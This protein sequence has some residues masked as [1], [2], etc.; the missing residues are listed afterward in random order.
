MDM[1]IV[2][3][4][5]SLFQGLELITKPGIRQFV[6]IP[7]LINILIFSI[8]LV[9]ANHYLHHFNQ[10]LA[11]YIPHWLLWLSWVIWLFFFLSFFVMFIYSFTTL[12]NIISAPFN[13]LLAE[14]VQEYLTGTIPASC[15]WLQSLKNVPNDFYRQISILGYYLPRALALLILFFVP[16]IHIF[17]G[18][19]WLIFNAW[20]LSLQYLDYPAV[21]HHIPLRQLHSLI[22]SK[23]S[24]C[25]GLGLATLFLSMIP[26]LNFIVMPV[27]IAGAT[28]LWIK[29][30]Q[31]NPRLTDQ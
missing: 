8:F 2:I 17:A 25:L 22:K 11:N 6:I 16:V 24:A 26:I 4:I 31:E 9:S 13:S 21:N 3:G 7:M 10:W 1:S 12:T 29:E 28:H 23:R 19:F 14:K 20:F 18:I 30:F 27:A 15:T 5:K